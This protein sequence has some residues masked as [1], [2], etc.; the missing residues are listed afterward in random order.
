[1]TVADKYNNLDGLRDKEA[2]LAELANIAAYKTENYYTQ[3]RKMLPDVVDKIKIGSS[4]TAEIVR[5]LRNFSRLDEAELKKA[6]I[7]EGID[8]TLLLLS[9]KLKQGIQVDRCYDPSIPLIDCYA[10]QLN[11]VFMNIISN[12]IDAFDEAEVQHPLITITTVLAPGGGSV[13]VSISDNAKGIPPEIQARIFDPFFTT[14]AVGKG[15]GLGLSISYGIVEK[16][17]GRIE[18]ESTPGQGT[19][20]HVALPVE[21]K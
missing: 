3:V 11:Q 7:H 4:R 5:G 16:H 13:V 20:F 14:K 19:T 15:T 18:L 6:D 9:S 21:I 8:S 1:L 2:L 17:R 10:G 12:A